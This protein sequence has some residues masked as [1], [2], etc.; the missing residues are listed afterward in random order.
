MRASNIVCVLICM[1]CSRGQNFE[2]PPLCFVQ[3]PGKSASCDC[4]H[5]CDYN[6]DYDPW[7]TTWWP[8]TV[9]TGYDCDYICDYNLDYNPWGTTL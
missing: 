7:G 9:T 4:D 2:V 5:I 8:H 1:C 6:L 3:Y